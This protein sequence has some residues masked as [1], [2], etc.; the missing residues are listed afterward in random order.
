MRLMRE[1]K[2]MVCGKSFLSDS[3]NASLCS[4]E[5]KRKRSRELSHEARKRDREGA[6]DNREKPVRRRKG[7]PMAQLT[8]DAIAAREAGLTYGKYKAKQFMRR[9]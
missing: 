1:I 8:A 3:W 7:K 6:L 5:C 9:G 4:L 2:C